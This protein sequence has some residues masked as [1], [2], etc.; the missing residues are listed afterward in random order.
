MDARVK[1]ALN[2]ISV[3]RRRGTGWFRFFVPLDGTSVALE[4]KIEA[5][6]QISKLRVS[7]QQSHALDEKPRL[8]AML[9]D[10]ANNRL[11]MINLML[12]EFEMSWEVLSTFRHR[13]GATGAIIEAAHY[14]FHEIV[15]EARD[16]ENDCA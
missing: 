1:N 4:L 15:K 14:R 13:E 2:L 16:S 3:N 5:S 9:I 10:A 8:K 12:E 11:A 7:D 6:G